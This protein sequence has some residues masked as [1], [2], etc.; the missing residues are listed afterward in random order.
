[1]VAVI[2]IIVAV[3]VV[4]L[5]YYFVFKKK[6]ELKETG[7]LIDRDNV[8]FRQKHIFTTKTASIAKVG[9]VLDISALTEA[10][11][12][13]FKAYDQDAIAFRQGGAGGTY[14]AGIRADKTEGELYQ[15]AFYVESW[16]ANGSS[17]YS[18]TDLHGANVLLTAIEKAFIALD[19]DTAV[20]REMTTHKTKSKWF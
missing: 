18:Y 17:Q 5:R 16:T 15:Y 9:E 1:M 12:T 2:F 8:F 7:K 3:G 19:P 4:A 6:A 14:E 11:I 20:R 10:K 13:V